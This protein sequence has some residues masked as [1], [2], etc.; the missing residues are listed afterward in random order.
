MALTPLPDPGPLEFEATLLRSDASGAACFVDFPWKLK[1]TFGRGNL[2][3]VRVLWDGQVEYQGSLA[4][5]G[6]EAAM[7]L[8]RKDVVAKLGKTA[9]DRVHVRVELDAAPRAVE[10]PEDL[11]AA[12]DEATLVSWNTLSLS[13]RREY[14]AWITDAKREETRQRRVAQ[15]LPM[16]AEGRKLKA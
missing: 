2:V 16:I 11:R 4:M 14:V 3:P 8:C 9:G 7:L 13:C 6:G 5:M 10:L 12:M 15:A 1:E